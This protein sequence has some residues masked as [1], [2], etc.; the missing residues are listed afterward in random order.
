[1]I[2]VYIYGLIPLSSQDVIHPIPYIIQNLI[3][4]D[5]LRVEFVLTV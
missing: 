5:V 2:Y 4:A 3:R 1:M